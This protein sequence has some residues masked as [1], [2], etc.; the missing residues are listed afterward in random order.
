M[1]F[2]FAGSFSTS[3]KKIGNSF[4]FPQHNAKISFPNDANN[5]VLFAFN[6]LFQVR[7]TLQID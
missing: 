4:I 2:T 1:C 7:Y 6:P 5:L 3:E